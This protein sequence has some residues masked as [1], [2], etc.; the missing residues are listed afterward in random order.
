MR[1]YHFRVVVPLVLIGV[2]VLFLTRP[3]GWSKYSESRTLMG[4]FVTLEVC[5][6]TIDEH[7]LKQ[8][9]SQVWEKL[10]A[11]EERM[12]VYNQ[13]SEVSTINEAGNEPVQISTEM[14]HVLRSSKKFNQLTQGAFDITVGPFIALWKDAQDAD[15]IPTEE[16]IQAVQRYVGMD[17][18]EINKDEV[19][20]TSKQVKIVL[21]AI[22]KGYAVDVAARIL[23]QHR[24][25]DFHINAGG[26]LFVQGF[27]CL[28]QPWRIGI[29]NPKN[30][31]ENVDILHLSGQAVTTSGDYEQF[32]QIQGQQWSH[33][34][35]PRTGYPQQSIM[36]ATVIA[37]T[38]MEADALSTALTVLSSEDGVA[39]MNTLGEGYASIVFSQDARGKMT[40]FKSCK[41]THYVK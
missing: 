36:S 29:R 4:T 21:G 9:F 1:K 35:D 27:N 5:Q 25:S 38:A 37:P 16:H 10:D 15:V 14:Y 2:V 22:A 3:K 18:I 11:I 33:I 8:V 34:I 32:Y 41:Y 31:N 28:R 39:L 6:P 19:R 30:K 17:N 26:D 40:S 23:S 24:I 13:K 20:K 12:S 7:Q